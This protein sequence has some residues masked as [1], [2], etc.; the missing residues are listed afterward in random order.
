MD[1]RATPPLV[2]DVEQDAQ[3]TAIL[4]ASLSS[5][6]DMT[7]HTS[8]DDAPPDRSEEQSRHLIIDMPP[9]TA[10]LP[11][12]LSQ[13]EEN[14][15][16]LLSGKHPAEDNQDDQND[17]D[18]REQDHYDACCT[19]VRP[20]RPLL[21]FGPISV[22]LTEAAD[23]GRSLWTSHTTSYAII[24]TASGA[25]FLSSI[26]LTGETTRENFDETC[27]IV[28]KRRF[29][30]DWPKLSK[31][32][33]GVAIALSA[34][35]AVWGPICEGMQAYYFMDGIPSEYHFEKSVNPVLWMVISS[36]VASGAGMTN[37]L[38][39]SAEM[40]KVIRE[41]LAG[42]HTPYTNS[43]ST[44]ASPLFGGA[45]GTLKSLQDSVQSYIA[46]KSIFSITSTHGR[47]LI[48]VPSMVNT[49][50]SFCFAG[51][52]NIKSLDEFFGYI[53]KR[54]IEPAKIAAFSLSLA[55]GI[56]LAFWKRALNTSFHKDVATDFGINN[57]TIPDEVYESLSWAMFVQ[58]S[59][60]ATACLYPPM[61][62]LV[63]RV[64]SGISRIYNG[65]CGLFSCG[66]PASSPDREE[67]ER[68]LS[69]DYDENESLLRD[70]HSRPPVAI[71]EEQEADFLSSSAHGRPPFPEGN[72][73]QDEESGL[74]TEREPARVSTHN[75][76]L[77]SS[78]HSSTRRSLSS[79]DKKPAT[80]CVLM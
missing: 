38:T 57:S 7:L 34:L 62:N 53:Q 47:I 54:K 19:T 18:D 9:D 3:L 51:L 12:R 56:Y 42:T 39:D 36:F 61:H 59:L 5:S 75:D 1:T 76:T 27:K 74:M 69:D 32:R 25:A 67:R 48:G 2:S 20:L 72:Q 79:A 45:M 73:P 43:F 40:Y 80:T 70:E 16:G 63:K 30:R 65:I 14:P 13:D 60:Q 71:N 64:S 66:D 68:L 4:P 10:S 55:L 37:A 33:E 17:Q 28:K 29:P 35:P 58:E 49:I 23:I 6:R 78:R 77:F 50:P 44:I 11:P 31:T 26:G 22:A 52:Y 24:I 46:I 8:S 41:R 15:S 21:Y